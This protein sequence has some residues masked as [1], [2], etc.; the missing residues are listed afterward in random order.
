MKDKQAHTDF[1]QYSWHGEICM[2]KLYALHR[3]TRPS[4][5]GRLRRALFLCIMRIVVLP[6]LRTSICQNSFAVEQRALASGRIKIPAWFLSAKIL[7]LAVALL[8]KVSRGTKIAVFIKKES[9]F[10]SNIPFYQ[11]PAVAALA[12]LVLL[13]YEQRSTYCTKC[14][15]KYKRKYCPSSVSIMS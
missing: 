9:T 14:S 6:T 3:L 1:A 7:N 5:C 2:R 13:H 11:S 15:S 4:R 8:C 12:K 10:Y